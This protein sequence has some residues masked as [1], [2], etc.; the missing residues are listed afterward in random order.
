MAT[1]FQS[2]PADPSRNTSGK[3]TAVWTA[4]IAALAVFMLLALGLPRL[5]SDAT[6]NWLITGGAALLTFLVVLGIARRSNRPATQATDD[7]TPAENRD[8]V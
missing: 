2:D 6:T 4:L 3:S 1:S 7:E 8:P 5:T